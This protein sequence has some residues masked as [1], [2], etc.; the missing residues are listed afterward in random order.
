VVG[1]A[2]A[3]VRHVIAA[4]NHHVVAHHARLAFLIELNHVV[5]GEPGRRE[6]HHAGG[7]FDDPGARSDDRVLHSG[8][9]YPLRDL[10]RQLGGHDVGRS[11]Q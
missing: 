1:H 4:E 6:L 7:T 11:A 9:R 2:W 8:E 3:A 5:L 10:A